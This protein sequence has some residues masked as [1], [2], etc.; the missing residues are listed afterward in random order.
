[1]TPTVID[2][3]LFSE[4]HEADILLAKL[5]VEQD[6]VDRWV[7]V[8]NAYT[9]KG[10]WKGVGLQA[11]L[12]DDRR[13]DPFLD[14]LD[15][16][17]IET[18][19]TSGFRPTKAEQARRRARSVLSHV[20][21]GSA[22]ALRAY[23]ERPYFYAEAA[24]R[25]AALPY[26]LEAAAGTD[27]LVCVSDVDEMV[28]GSDPGRRDVVRRAIT[29]DT[30]VVHLD[31]RRFAYDFDNVVLGGFRSVP[32]VRTSA[33]LSG[34]ASLGQVRLVP[35]GVVAGPMP[36]A[37]EYSY[38]YGAEGLRRKLATFTHLDP[39]GGVVDQALMFNHQLKLAAPGAIP[40]YSYWHEQVPPE[41]AGHPLY[42]LENMDR[43]RTGAVNPDY[44]QARRRAFPQVFG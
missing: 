26:V 39:G 12:V 27:A 25:D 38:C 3:F 4:P 32:A 5:S 17:S 37:F 34:R 40:H 36:V 35:Q 11:L 30:P 33:L 20:H 8:E 13:F 15:V 9:I 16:V 10:E 6:L 42:I 28:D 23:A 44:R 7:A 19:F 41:V 43:L 21:A 18:D 14:R 29:A 2:T 22:G 1:M 24:Q 31:R